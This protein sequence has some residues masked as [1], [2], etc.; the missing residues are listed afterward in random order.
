MI[1]TTR[2]IYVLG[3]IGIPAAVR[4]WVKAKHAR[5]EK[6]EGVLPL[7]DSVALEIAMTPKPHEDVDVLA[8]MR[9]TLVLLNQRT[10]ASE[11]WNLDDQLVK[12][13][14]QVPEASQPTVKAAVVRLIESQDRWLQSV[15]VNSA[16][17]LAMN[18]AIPAI[19]ALKARIV[20]ASD[21][22]S[23]HDDALFV[24]SLDEALLIIEAGEQAETP[25]PA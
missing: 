1:T 22:E 14:D 12:Y 2:F 19:H 6:V 9:G 7:F 16:S 21:R 4:F 18:E 13:Y 5:R 24:A 15:G 3:G 23:G 11:F 8:E 17:G 20:A 10:F 25:S